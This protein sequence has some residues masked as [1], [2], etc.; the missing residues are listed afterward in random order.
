MPASPKPRRRHRSE[1]ARLDAVAESLETYLVETSRQLHDK[2]LAALVARI[3]VQKVDI[4]RKAKEAN[5]A[6]RLRLEH[7]KELKLSVFLEK[8][9]KIDALY[10]IHKNA[11][12]ESHVQPDDTRVLLGHASSTPA[13]SP[14]PTIAKSAPT[15]PGRSHPELTNRPHRHAAN[16]HPATAARQDASPQRNRSPGASPPAAAAP[17]PQ[18][19]YDAMSPLES[20]GA[21][22]VQSIDSFIHPSSSSL[23]PL[24][25]E[26]LLHV[27]A[28]WQALSTNALA[29]THK[30]I[31]PH[32]TNIAS[33]LPSEL[34][35]LIVSS[36]QNDLENRP[37][38]QGALLRT[39]THIKTLIPKNI[40]FWV[41]K[42]DTLVTS[43]MMIWMLFKV[44]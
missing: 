19:A 13:S 40:K 2:K 14:L 7:A 29:Y 16:D 23:D 18:E 10:A 9:T 35:P 43:K 8:K 38:P 20:D 4:A 33:L 11:S 6:A 22:S 34:N 36:I 17:D 15:S 12:K 25:R 21:S 39:N 37:V 44:R 5:E 30:M 31:I 41:L 42:D 26:V 32:H 1:N 3:A 24:P 27:P 28:Q